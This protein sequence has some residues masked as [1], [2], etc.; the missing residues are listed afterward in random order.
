VLHAWTRLAHG[1][2]QRGLEDAPAV[3]AACVRAA[4]LAPDDPTPWVVLL[5]VARLEGRRQQEVFGVWNEA[6]ARDRWNREAYL[7][8]LGYL[9]PREAGSRLQVLEFV[10]SLRAHVPADAPCAATGTSTATTLRDLPSLG[11]LSGS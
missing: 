5:G 8:M 6:V 3:A 7:A 10:D 1:R 9:G 4:E 11:S 2:A